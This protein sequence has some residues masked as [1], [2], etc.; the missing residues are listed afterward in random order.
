MKM[1]NLLFVRT[2]LSFLKKRKISL[3]CHLHQEKKWWKKS[4][5][6]P[7]NAQF[8]HSYEEEKD[9]QS[10]PICHTGTRC[11]RKLAW[12]IRRRLDFWQKSR[13]WRSPEHYQQVVCWRTFTWNSTTCLPRRSRRGKLTWTF[14]ERFMTFT[15][16]WWRRA[17]SA[18]GQSRDLTDHAWADKKHKNL[19]TLF[20]FGSWFDKN[21]R[22]NLWISDCFGWCD[23]TF[24][25][26]SI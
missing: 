20:F 1:I 16:T 4:V 17:H 22:P 15:S 23:I 14:L 19:E 7:Q 3:W 18:I 9:L 11:V 13:R 5:N 12:A 26:I 8:R 10:G 2:V 24:N 25:S 6:L 21:W